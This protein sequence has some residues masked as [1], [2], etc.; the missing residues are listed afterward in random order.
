MKKQK[1]RFV[2]CCECGHEYNLESVNGLFFQKRCPCCG[3][4]VWFERILRAVL[5]S[6]DER[7]F[8]RVMLCARIL[9]FSCVV[10]TVLMFG[11]LLVDL[12]DNFTWNSFQYGLLLW[13]RNIGKLLLWFATNGLDY[14]RFKVETIRNFRD[15]ALMEWQR[16][17][18]V[19][20]FLAFQ[21]FDSF[22]RIKLLWKQ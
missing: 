19:F 21:I 20:S 22:R 15:N 12:G 11:W 14:F 1:P 7:F 3:A 5:F 9:S 4:P 10:M 17:A 8:G 18:S 16:L 13:A 2:I 6:I